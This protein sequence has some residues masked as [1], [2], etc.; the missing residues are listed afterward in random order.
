M[1]TSVGDLAINVTTNTATVE[2]A[3]NKLASTIDGTFGKIA[4]AIADVQRGGAAL[5]ETFLKLG[6][7]LA[8]AIGVGSFVHLIEG[9]IAGQAELARLAERTGATVESLSAMRTAAK[10]A[11]VGMDDVAK[12]LQ[13]F[14]VAITAAQTG[15]GKQAEALTALGFNAKTFA[16]SFKTTDEAVLAVAQRLNQYSDGIGKTAIQQNLLG[17]SGA[18]LAVFLREVAERGLDNVKVTTEQAKAAKALEDSIIKLKSGFTALINSI[19]TTLVPILQKVVDGME[20]FKLIAEAAIL[21]FVVWPAT[22]GLVTAALTAYRE[23]V[24]A[25]ALANEVLGASTSTLGVLFTNFFGSFKTLFGSFAAL[26]TTLPA[27]IFAAFAG[28]QIGTFLSEQF[29]EVRVAALGFVGAVE[30][31]FE[32]IKYAGQV[33][34][35]VLKLGF[36]GMVN[37]VRDILAGFIDKVAAG[38]SYIPGLDAISSQIAQFASKVKSSGSAIVDFD[39]NVAKLGAQNTAAKAKIDEITL[40]LQQFEIKAHLAKK[41]A[42]DAAKAPPP[43]P[44]EAAKALK[45]TSRAIDDYLKAL[46]GL[47]KAYS[48]SIAKQQVN[49][50]QNAEA[51]LQRAYSRGLVDFRQYYDQ[52]TALQAAALQIE[53]R[54]IKEAIDLQTQ[55]VAQLQAVADKTR[56]APL[57]DPAKQLIAETNANKELIVANTTLLTLRGNLAVAVQKQAQVGKDYIEVLIAESNGILKS[58]L[59]LERE[60]DS[61]ELANASIG[62]TASEVIDLSIARVQEKLANTNLLEQ[63]P[64]LLDFYDKQIDR[65]GKLRA[66]TAKGE[67]IQQQ[68]DDLRSLFSTLDST[69]RDVF[70][71]IGQKG[72][73]MWTKIK[74]SGKKILLDFLYSLTLKPFLISI[75]A[76]L[77]GVA[78]NAAANVLGG[79]Q[80]NPLSYL[81][82]GGGLLFNGAPTGGNGG[83]IVPG[84]GG[85]FSGLNNLPTLIG[86]PSFSTAV[87]N[88]STILPTFSASMASGAGIFSSASAAFAG[89]AASF[90]TVAIPILGL[91][92]PLLS[93]LFNK[94]PSEVKGQFGISSGT[95]GFEDNA[96]T[97][98]KFGNVGFLDANTQQFSGDAAQVLNK[99]IAGALDAF[100]TRY[101]AEQSARLATILQ[102]TTFATQEGTFNTQDFLQKY[103]GQVLQQ[104][105][106]AAFDVLDPALG[107]VAAGFKGTADEVAKFGNT[108]LAVYDATKAIGNADFTAGV[109]AALQGANQ[110]TADK[111]LAFV[112][113]VKSIGDGLDGLGPKLQ[114]LDPTKIVEFIDA[115]GGAQAAV[116]AFAFLNAN[117]TTAAERATAAQTNLTS[118]WNAAGI[119]AAD[120]AS[121]GLDHLPRTHAEFLQLFNTLVTGDARA[122]ALAATMLTNVAPAFVAVQGSADAAADALNRQAQAGRDYYN[123][124][125]ATP[126]EQLL[127]RQTV[128][129]TAI[130][131][132]TRQTTALGQALHGLGFDDLPLTVDGVRQMRRALVAVYGE[133]SEVVKQFDALVPS[134]GD[135]I[136]SIGGFKKVVDET[137]VSV[138]SL[139]KA[140]ASLAQQGRDAA[141]KLISSFQTLASS[142]S[143]DFG[144]KLGLQIDLITGALKQAGATLTGGGITTIQHRGQPDETVFQ[145]LTYAVAGA[146]AKTKAYIDSLAST[147]SQYT[148]QLSR[149]TI[150]SAQYDASIAEQLVSLQDWDTQQKAIFTGNAAALAALDTIFKQRW[151]AIINGASDAAQSLDDFIKKIQGIADATGGN[152]GQQARLEQALSSAKLA[153]LTTKYAAA[154]PGS[155]L[156]KSI[157]ADIAKL[158]AY[159]AVLG[160]Q[161]EHFAT[162]SAQYGADVANQLVALE[163]QFETWKTSVAGNADALAIVTEIFNEKFKSIVDGVKDGVDQL[164]KLKVDIADY[165]KSLS[166]GDLSPLKPQQKLDQSQTAY[167]EELLRAQHGDLTALGDITRY[168]DAYLNQA[169]DFFASSQ[170]YTDIFTSVTEQLAELAG[171]TSTG[172]PTAAPAIDSHLPAGPLASQE[173]VQANTQATRDLEA[174][175]VAIT[176]AQH[177]QSTQLTEEQTVILNRMLT[178]SRREPIV[179]K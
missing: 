130:Y 101:S 63:T 34:W 132:A 100:S 59:A 136:D 124:H 131:E 128:D 177:T 24:L 150:L 62:K 73:D 173:D 26:L 98:S 106:A 23:A 60:I 22:V 19:A 179:A 116:N 157:Q 162:Y 117:F 122:Q 29:V 114:A 92:I 51:D 148:D 1:A 152:A 161:I 10:Y 170:S 109:D 112:T 135:L 41:A 83:G 70:D 65:L 102:G 67:G 154:L 80:G 54:Q 78:G 66:A 39:A 97:A 48:E 12:G 6:G 172:L 156:A 120:L 145:P 138:G 64:E 35:E 37:Q 69:A 43:V 142:S 169:R 147:L 18:N 176:T 127:N 126:Q 178:A 140:T 118:A 15:T 47:A 87:S 2:S 133:S 166:I 14:A 111:V 77:T 76:S 167:V 4:S 129:S 103:G 104:V 119:T 160:T 38:L 68:F 13:K 56:T 84:G 72:A 44:Q 91:A 53:E 27:L 168:A 45:D 94:K 36:N 96:F 95:T 144:S 61:R 28:F 153:D 110:E 151:D 21:A 93:G 16:T 149:F 107:A 8:G 42:E 88:L 143:G 89:T 158:T 25:A 115:L 139:I 125:F 52:K 175:L 55:L 108:L 7:I 141:D 155:A 159:N 137:I 30:K 31:G 171:T 163:G 121:A 40:D 58:N 50:I 81:L 49:A 85:F 134:M 9:A 17:K 5:G 113:I 57:A 46:T 11:G 33:A 71:S 75:A 99:V 20:H 165:L 79:G 174:T 3:F 123:Q 82:S 164:S 32:N 86:L 90:A 105:I 146:D 74:E